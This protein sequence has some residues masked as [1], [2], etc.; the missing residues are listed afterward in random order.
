M[1]SGFGEQ[2][3]PGGNPVAAQ[4]TCTLPVKPPLGVTVMVDMPLLPAVTVTGVAVMLNEPEETTLTE[5][6]PE[7]PEGE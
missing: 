5:M 4:V 7:G 6:A 1:F 2:V 3:T